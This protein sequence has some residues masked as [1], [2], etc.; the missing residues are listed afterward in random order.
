MS[1]TWTPCLLV[2]CA[3]SGGIALPGVRQEPA[4]FTGWLVGW[5]DYSLTP[6][7]LVPGTINCPDHVAAVGARCKTSSPLGLTGHTGTSE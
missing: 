2:V 3:V 6:Y 5:L 7:G 4:V 1:V